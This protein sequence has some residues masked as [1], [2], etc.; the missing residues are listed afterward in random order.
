MVRHIFPLDVVGDAGTQL[1]D[2]FRREMEDL[3]GRLQ[4]V[5]GA[6]GNGET[7]SFTPRTNVVETE[8]AFELT[9]DLPGMKSADFNIELHEGRLSITGERV[10][11]EAVEG[12]KMLRAERSFGKFVRTF[13]LG[14]DVDAEKVSAEY[15]DGVLQVVVEKTAQAQPTKIVVK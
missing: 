8:T 6:V 15:T 14:H 9:L 10:A 3:A 12:R 7:P 5:D 13:N 1:L 11:E 4:E 2:V